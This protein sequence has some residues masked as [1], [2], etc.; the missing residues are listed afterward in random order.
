M[1]EKDA[2]DVRRALKRINI[3]SNPVELAKFFGFRFLRGWNLYKERKVVKYRSNPGGRIA[4]IVEGKGRD[5]Q[6]LP[7]AC[8]CSCDDFYFAVI[9]DKALVCQHL[10]AAQLAKT[11]SSYRVIEVEDVEFNKLTERWREVQ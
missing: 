10:I 2:E 6:I 1:S 7:N 3:D 4:W 9:E 8:F 5:Y 11:L